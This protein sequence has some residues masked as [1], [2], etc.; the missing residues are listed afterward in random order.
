MPV[1]SCD[2]PCMFRASPSGEPPVGYS[3]DVRQAG[4]RR[5]RVEADHSHKLPG[6]EQATT[7]RCARDRR[8]AAPF[9]SYLRA[10]SGCGPSHTCDR[11]RLGGT[12]GHVLSFGSA[13]C[14]VAS[15]TLRN[16]G[17]VS[18]TSAPSFP[19]GDLSAFCSGNFRRQ[20]WLHGHHEDEKTRNHRVR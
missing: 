8:Y 6:K 10:L 18:F 11:P 2:Q 9:S 12:M 16:L 14:T 7:Q 19:R 4:R 3:C 1:S 15:W 20:T 13:H 17:Q 5:D